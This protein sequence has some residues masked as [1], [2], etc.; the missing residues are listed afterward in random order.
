MPHKY[1]S[2]VFYYFILSEDGKSFICKCKAKGDTEEECGEK[3]SSFAEESLV[4]LQEH[5]I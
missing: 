3:I 2:A 1:K 4:H 5:L